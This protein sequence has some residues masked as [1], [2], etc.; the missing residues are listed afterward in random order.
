MNP[1]PACMNPPLL[2]LN[3]PPLSLNPPPPTPSRWCRATPSAAATP[4]SSRCSFPCRPRP[5]AGCTPAPLSA[6]WRPYFCRA[7]RSAATSSAAQISRVR[8]RSNS[9]TN[10]HVTSTPCVLSS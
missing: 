5:A 4:P 9:A 2:S 3:P 10:N 8:C 7:S 1:H 6:S